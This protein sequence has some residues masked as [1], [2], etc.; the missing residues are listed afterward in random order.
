MDTILQLSIPYTDDRSNPLKLPPKFR[1][2]T[3]LLYLAFV[4]TRRL[5]SYD[6]GRVAYCYR[7]DH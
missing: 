5:C 4:I 7:G 2:F 1:N 6:H 3:H